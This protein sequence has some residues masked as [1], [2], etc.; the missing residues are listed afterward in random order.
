MYPWKKQ[1]T[2]KIGVTNNW[3]LYVDPNE[4]LTTFMVLFCDDPISMN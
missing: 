2:L 4:V 3:C 1:K